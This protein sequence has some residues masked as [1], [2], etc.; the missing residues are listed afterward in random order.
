MAEETNELTIND[1]TP[2]I[3]SEDLNIPTPINFSI[4]EVEPIP[5]DAVYT[6]EYN[7]DATI[8]DNLEPDNT[9]PPIN[10]NVP[11]NQ[12]AS[13]KDGLKVDN[14]K[15]KVYNDY[16]WFQ[17]L[18]YSMLKGANYM[19]TIPFAEMTDGWAIEN[20]HEWANE[21]RKYMEGEYPTDPR[22]A[23]SKLG[24]LGPDTMLAIA[25]ITAS[26]VAPQYSSAIMK[27]YQTYMGFMSAGMGLNNARMYED[28]TGEKLSML[29]E[30]SIAVGH[31]IAAYTTEKWG[32]HNYAVM[33]G[34]DVA[35]GKVDDVVMRTA[36]WNRFGNAFIKLDRD[37]LVNVL[38]D[39]G[40]ASGKGFLT[41]GQQE[42]SEEGL[43]LMADKIIYNPEGREYM[44]QMMEAF[45]YGGIAGGVIGQYT[46]GLN[47]YYNKKRIQTLANEHT[48]GDIKK[49]VNQIWEVGSV[50]E[51]KLADN[52]NEVVE[53]LMNKLESKKVLEKI[54]AGEYKIEDVVN[55]FGEVLGT[56]TNKKD[57]MEH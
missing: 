17:D 40:E 36:L 31:G 18:T 28:E 43:K 50:E 32:M 12:P 22:A 27:S 21:H 56:V 15:V 1:N 3:N 23:A 37:A 5:S 9:P 26:R 57:V 47:S 13:I 39:M 53:H 42:M 44:M 33:T 45:G 7:P 4:D 6:S 16:P 49:L 14:T 2:G 24:Q 11:P 35:G 25:S 46:Y 41:E 10:D 54:N 38:K 34:I 55:E 19:F 29:Q 30:M 51:I 48:N 52:Y 20:A 8:D